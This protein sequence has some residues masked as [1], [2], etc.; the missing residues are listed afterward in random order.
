L[1]NGLI[2]SK[3]FDIPT[4]GFEKSGPPVDPELFIFIGSQLD[5]IEA[6]HIENEFASIQMKG[7]DI[8]KMHFSFDKFN[9]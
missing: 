9:L 2:F 5:M 1:K 8:K 4:C 7:F 6:Y 3:H